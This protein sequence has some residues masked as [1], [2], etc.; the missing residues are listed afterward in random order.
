MFVTPFLVSYV[1]Y[2]P[3]A[4]YDGCG[5]VASVYWLRLKQFVVPM[6]AQSIHGCDILGAIW[7]WG[8]LVVVSVCSMKDIP[9][10][11]LAQ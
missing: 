8:C 2:P 3:V 7:V 4:V 5:S 11:P 6:K 10:E 1:N 9:I